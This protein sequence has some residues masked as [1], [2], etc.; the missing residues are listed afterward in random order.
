[1]L[2]LWQRRHIWAFTLSRTILRQL[3][4]FPTRLRRGCLGKYSILT[5]LLQHSLVVHRYSI[6]DIAQL[7]FPSTLMTGNF[8]VN[9]HLMVLK[10]KTSICMDGIEIRNSIQLLFFEHGLCSTLS[11]IPYWRLHLVILPFVVGRHCCKFHP[12]P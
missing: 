11:E 6:G 3:R 9:P 2:R 10:A 8:W 7:V 1:M 12:I 4:P 5:R